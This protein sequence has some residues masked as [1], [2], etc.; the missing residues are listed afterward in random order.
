MRPRCTKPAGAVGPS[1]CAQLGALV[2]KCFGL[3]P[4][5]QHGGFGGCFC[6]LPSGSSRAA[7]FPAPLAPK[8]PTAPQ[9]CG[10]AQEAKWFTPYRGSFSP[11]CQLWCRPPPTCPAPSCSTC[12][13]P[14]PC[15][16]PHA[17]RALH[18]TGRCRR[19]R[20]AAREASRA[21]CPQR[22]H[23]PLPSL[24]SE[25]NN[26]LLA[27]YGKQLQQPQPHCLGRTFYNLRRAQAAGGAAA[28]RARDAL[29]VPW[30]KWE[31]GGTTGHPSFSWALREEM[32]QGQ[33]RC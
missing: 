22:S 5:A 26:H 23:L 13:S 31:V 9:P 11:S 16:Q 1:C 14:W 21:G 4:A 32:G 30:H 24:S 27:Q 19:P 3:S 20:V 15:S 10:L 7:A 8:G 12:R 2:A 6:A 25:F 33:C 28:P 29:L 17:A 18:G